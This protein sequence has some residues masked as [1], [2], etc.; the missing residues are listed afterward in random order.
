MYQMC[1][2]IPCIRCV[3][4]Q[5]VTGQLYDKFTF[6]SKFEEQVL[7]KFLSS[8]PVENW[9]MLFKYE[10]ILIS[11][12]RLNLHFVSKI[13]IFEQSSCW[14]FVH[15]LIPTVHANDH[16]LL[17]HARRMIIIYFINPFQYCLPQKESILQN[18]NI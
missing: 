13:L 5:N 16:H 4:S 12:L 7:K 15:L 9:I 3:F 17:G 8:K 11:L 2:I 10:H 6:L 1:Q 14:D 18:K